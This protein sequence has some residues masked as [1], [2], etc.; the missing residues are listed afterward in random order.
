[1]HT[2]AQVQTDTRICFAIGSWTIHRSRP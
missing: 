2:Q 1:M